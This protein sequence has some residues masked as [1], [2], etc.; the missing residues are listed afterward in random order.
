M[1][2]FNIN[3]NFQN[4]RN[5]NTFGF[6]IPEKEKDTLDNFEGK[7]S[8]EEMAGVLDSRFFSWLI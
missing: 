6:T 4:Q 5:N 2:P 8:L 3:N 7:I 1:Y